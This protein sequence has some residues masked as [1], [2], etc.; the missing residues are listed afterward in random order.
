MFDRKKR[1]PPKTL[2]SNEIRALLADSTA[3]FRRHSSNPR[4]SLSACP[5][6]EIEHEDDPDRPTDSEDEA[7]EEG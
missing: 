6:T 3:T 4:L 5:A 1:T 7:L 2:P